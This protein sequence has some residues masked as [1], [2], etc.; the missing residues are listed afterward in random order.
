MKRTLYLCHIK[1]VKNTTETSCSYLI[2]SFCGKTNKK[3]TTVDTEKNISQA[4]S[5]E[6]MEVEM[7]PNNNEK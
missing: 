1:I 4:I 6:S 7:G 3:Q 2:M 5:T